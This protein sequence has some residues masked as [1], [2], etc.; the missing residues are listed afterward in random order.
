MKNIV[1]QCS[2]KWTLFDIFSP[3]AYDLVPH[4]LTN[5]LPVKVLK[6]PT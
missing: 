2:G 3:N 1:I 6:V 5:G 4:R